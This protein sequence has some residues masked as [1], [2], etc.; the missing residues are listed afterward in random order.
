MIVIK[1]SQ[2]N[3]I[4]ALNNPWANMPSNKQTKLK[5]YFQKL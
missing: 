3:L 5:N 4:S 1:D 2:M